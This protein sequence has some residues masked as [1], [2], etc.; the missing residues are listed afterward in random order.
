MAAFLYYFQNCEVF[1]D[2]VWVK[3]CS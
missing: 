1:V 3:Y 2:C